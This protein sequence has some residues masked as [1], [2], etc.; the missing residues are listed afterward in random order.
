MGAL[1]N[2]NVPQTHEEQLLQQALA[3]SLADADEAKA[4][5]EE[6]TKSDAMDQDVEEEPEAEEEEEKEELVLDPQPEASDPNATAIRIRTP[7]GGVLQ[8]HFLKDAKVQQLY[9]WCRLSLGGQKVSL[10]QTMPRLRLDDEKEKTLKELGL[11]RATL[12]CSLQ[13]D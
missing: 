5:S 9:V 3:A 6:Q 1:V 12:V 7:N 11:I 2:H 4:N 10:L 8:R 13:D